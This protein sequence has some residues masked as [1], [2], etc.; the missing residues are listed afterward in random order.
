MF[1]EQGAAQFRLFTGQEAPREVMRAALDRSLPRSEIAA[2][3][4]AGTRPPRRR[5]GRFRHDHR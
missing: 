4:G 3:G 2:P 5:S 1:L